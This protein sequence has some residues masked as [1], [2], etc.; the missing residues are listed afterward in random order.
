[1]TAGRGKERVFGYVTDISISHKVHP[2]IN[3]YIWF[4]NTNDAG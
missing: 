3:K 2:Q 4:I 1:M